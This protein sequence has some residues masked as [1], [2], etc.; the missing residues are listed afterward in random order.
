ML[1]WS[2][3]IADSMTPLQ[4]NMLFSI[5]TLHLQ[6]EQTELLPFSLTLP[7]EQSAQTVVFTNRDN[8]NRA[9]RSGVFQ[10]SFVL[11][12]RSQPTNVWSRAA[13]LTKQTYCWRRTQSKKETAFLLSLRDCSLLLWSALVSDEVRKWTEKGLHPHTPPFYFFSSE[14]AGRIWHATF[15]GRVRST[16]N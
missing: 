10:N 6:M 1:Q 2:K 15:C 8:V 12:S 4:T 13:H 7:A 16:K 5:D 3:T 9:I 11:R 14:Y